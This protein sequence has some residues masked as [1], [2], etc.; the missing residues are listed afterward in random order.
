LRET[1]PSYSFSLNSRTLGRKPDDNGDGGRLPWLSTVRWSLRS[2]GSTVRTE[3]WE[4]TI[5]T[6]VVDTLAD[7]FSLVPLQETVLDT[8]D[9]IVSERSSSSRH[10]LNLSD[11]RKILG[12]INVGPS[13]TATESWVDREFALEDT[14]RGFRRALT[15]NASL[16]A[17]TTLY[18]TFPGLGPVRALRHTMSPSVSFG[19]QP[20]FGSL[21][22]EDT[23]G[24]K[25]SRFPGV[26]ASK[27]KRLSLALSNKFQA[28]VA[29]GD[30]VKRVELFNWNLNTSYD[31][32]AEERGA[33]PWGTIASSVDLTRI[34][35]LGLTFNSSHDPYHQLRTLNFSG[36][37]AF[38]LRGS[39]PGGGSG[40]AFN[41]VFASGRRG[42]LNE[43]GAD[44]FRSAS[45]VGSAPVSDEALDWNASMSLSYSGG[46][47]G[48]E[49]KTQ[50]SINS[51]FGLQITRNWSISYNN[52]WRV[53]EGEIVGESF[54]LRRD[55]HCWEATFTGS[56]LGDDTSF[57]FR[58]N[59]KALPD[60]KYEQGQRGSDFGGLT[61]FLP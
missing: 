35:G 20:E 32:L 37:G 58:I 26:F 45:A 10:T 59:A 52:T 53:T 46:R 54:S 5:N 14:T 42:D 47:I 3:N 29:S 57:Y 22:Y 61:S 13:F 6:T 28:K 34:L 48:E 15:Y 36:Q 25:R 51:R 56:K 55:L 11:T 60:V 39:L 43:L 40:V 31:F 38:S 41:P 4:R 16:N 33:R 9:R 17:S 24:V 50:T 7:A 27:S 2:S 23:L 18:G 44:V 49:L 19:Y 12:A 30:D 8:V 21:T 1:L